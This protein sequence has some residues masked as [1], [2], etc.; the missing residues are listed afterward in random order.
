MSSFVLVV[1]AFNPDE[2]P[3]NILTRSAAFCRVPCAWEFRDG[4]DQQVECAVK[5]DE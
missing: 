5:I 4:A 2:H 1:L 3:C